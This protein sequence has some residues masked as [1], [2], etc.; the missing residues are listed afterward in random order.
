MVANTFNKLAQ[1]AMHCATMNNLLATFAMVSA[2]NALLGAK[3]VDVHL[4]KREVV[5]FLE[6]NS[7]GM[8]HVVLQCHC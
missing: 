4:C 2:F 3:K 7:L 6:Q 5:L 8:L 1:V